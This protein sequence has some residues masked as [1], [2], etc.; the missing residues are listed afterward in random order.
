MVQIGAPQLNGG[1]ELGS[2]YRVTDAHVLT[3]THVIGSARTETIAVQ[4]HAG[5]WTSGVAAH[6]D[7]GDD[8][9]L[10]ELRQPV[11]AETS[12]RITPPP[13]GRLDESPGLMA[14]VAVGYPRRARKNTAADLTL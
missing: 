3:A 4:S 11:A 14:A 12:Q 10:L 13:Y 9:S 8:L 5:R 6:L 1:T 2:G 7:L